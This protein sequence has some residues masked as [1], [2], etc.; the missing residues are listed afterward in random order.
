MKRRDGA[1]ASV[2][3][4]LLRRGGIRFEEP[5][6]GVGDGREGRRLVVGVHAPRVTGPEAERD[7]RSSLRDDGRGG[8]RRDPGGRLHGA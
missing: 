1:A 7:G 8:A 4:E 2:L 5:A 6:R 3:A